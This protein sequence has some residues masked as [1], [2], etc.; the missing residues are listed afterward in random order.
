[1]KVISHVSWLTWI[2][3]RHESGQRGNN[4]AALFTVECQVRLESHVRI[5]E[6]PAFASRVQEYHPHK[7]IFGPIVDQEMGHSR[8]FG[9]IHRNWRV[10]LDHDS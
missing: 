4:G 6:G 7:M 5:R 9:S 10:K 2:V 1:M 8:S 3:S